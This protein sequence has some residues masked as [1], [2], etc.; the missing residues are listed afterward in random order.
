MGTLIQWGIPG[1]YIAVWLVYGRWLSVQ[2]LDA[3]VRSNMRRYPR[4]YPPNAHGAAKIADENRGVCMASGMALGLCWPVVGLVYGVYRLAT[5]RG[6]FRTPIE[7]E[8]ADRDELARL[9]DLAR[10]H[11]L[12][13]PEVKP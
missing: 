3:S 1:I 2:F 11:N 5:S 7:R 13:M 8:F 4:L 9:R 12:P 10:Q 6:L